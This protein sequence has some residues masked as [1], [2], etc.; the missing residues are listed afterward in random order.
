MTKQKELRENWKTFFATRKAKSYDFATYA[1]LRAMFVNSNE[2]KVI[3]ARELLLKHFTPCNNKIKN[4]NGWHKYKAIELAV[5]DSISVI[6]FSWV[7]VELT[8]DE[9]FEFQRIQRKIYKELTQSTN[10]GKTLVAYFITRQDISP[11]QQLVQ[12]AHVASVLGETRCSSMDKTTFVVI[13][14]ESLTELK[15]WLTKLDKLNYHVVTFN[16]PDLNNELTS[17]AVLPEW[18][19]YK[20]RS[21][22][23]LANCNLLT[24]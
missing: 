1:I 7:K 15:Q 12:T 14:C 2:D 18:L 10:F 23:I 6:L 4:D 13:G 22:H 16:E 8:T 17:I 9:I 11:E 5:A 24:F 3:I 21:N 19:S 20:D